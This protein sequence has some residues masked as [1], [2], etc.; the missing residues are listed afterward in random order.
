MKTIKQIAE[1]IG[2]SKQA[3]HQKI[4]RQPLAVNVKPFTSTV[5]GAIYIENEGIT[6]IKSAF[7]DI[8]ADRQRPL[9]VDVNEPSTIVNENR[10]NADYKPFPTV[11]E[12]VNGPS[13]VDVLLSIVKEQQQTIKELTTANRE[14]TTAI[15]NTTASLHAAQALHAGTMQ[16][17]LTNGSAKPNEETGPVRI[18]WFQRIFKKS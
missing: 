15:E 7:E 5:D 14:L 3:V 13:T 1:E 8:N 17:K 18:N 10:D 6:L 9:S 11:N 12:A 4:K 16:N 2:V